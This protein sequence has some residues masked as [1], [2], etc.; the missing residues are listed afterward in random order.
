MALNAEDQARLQRIESSLACTDPALARRFRSWRPPS[1][2]RP[3]LPGW[4][5]VPGWAMAVFLVGFTWWVLSPVVGVLVVIGFAA[6][7][8]HQR[9]AARARPA[10]RNGTRGTR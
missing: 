4:S 7:W 8:V 10:R 2:Q 3:T 9:A 5:A 6:F 1:G